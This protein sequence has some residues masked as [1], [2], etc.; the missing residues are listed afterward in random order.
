MSNSCHNFVTNEIS[1][2]EA[3]DVEK[4]EVS[5]IQNLSHPFD[6]NSVSMQKVFVIENRV[7]LYGCFLF[8]FR[9]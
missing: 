9:F 6:L 3:Y 8:F 7:E 1:V 5:S 4:E 2:L